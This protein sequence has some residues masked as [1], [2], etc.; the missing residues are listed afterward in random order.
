MACIFPSRFS[1]VSIT[2]H[3]SSRYAL[4]PNYIILSRLFSQRDKKKES[5]NHYLLM[6]FSLRSVENLNTIFW[7][8]NI[9]TVFSSLVRTRCVSAYEK[10]VCL[11]L[12]RTL[13]GSTNKPNTCTSLSLMLHS[14]WP[15]TCVVERREP[16]RYQFN[17]YVSILN[18]REEKRRNQKKMI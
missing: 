3:F 13:C 17:T 18:R 5:I 2:L 6:L 10:W 15:R 9:F 4:V 11:P 14:V 1:P 8:H 12:T 7:G 16:C